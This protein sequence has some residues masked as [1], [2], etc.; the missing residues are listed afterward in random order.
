M[1]RPWISA[2]LA[3][4]A[5]G[6]ISDARQRPSGWTSKADHDRLMALRR[7]A[8][9]L[10]VGRGTL[11]KDRMSLRSPGSAEPPLRCIV[12]R[13]GRIPPDHPV[14]QTEGGTVHLLI[15]GTAESPALPGVVI[16]RESLDGFVRLL[17]ESHGV[18]RLHCEGGGELI[19]SLAELDL[20]DELHLTLAGHTIFGGAESPT[21][22]GIPGDFLPASREFTLHGFEPQPE[23]GE[24]FLTYRRK[25]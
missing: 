16:H 19:R 1:S 20:L 25:R 7:N 15:T 9:A 4:S 14:F 2:N 3:I 5:D 22:T 10:I 17:A 24:C 13:S 12:S 11:E 21:A 8:D 18:G 6:K 23:T